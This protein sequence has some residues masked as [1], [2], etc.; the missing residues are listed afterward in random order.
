M[1]TL[2][3]AAWRHRG[4]P[5]RDDVLARRLRETC[6]QLGPTF[7]KA[8][9]LLSTRPDFVPRSYC[10]EL[11][12]CLDQIQP[13]PAAELFAELE[14]AWGCSTKK[15]LKKLELE[16]IG[17]GSL[18]QVYRGELRTGEIVAI[19][20][21]RPGVEAVVAAD[22]RVLRLLAKVFGNRIGTAERGYWLELVAEVER[23]L[24]MEMNYERELQNAEMMRRELIDE[25]AIRIPKMYANLSSRR[26]LVMEYLAGESLLSIMRRSR[27]SKSAAGGARARR[28]IETAMDVLGI[29]G[30]QRSYFHAD[31]HPGNLLLQK[32]GSLALLD[33]GLVQHFSPRLRRGMLMFL[34]GAVLGSPELLIRSARAVARFSPDFDTDT[35]IEVLGVLCERYR[36]ARVSEMSFGQFTFEI[37]ALCLETG[38]QF[39]W[40][41][42]LY[43]R[44]ALHLDGIALTLHPEIV[45][46]EYAERRLLGIYSA[47]LAE[48]IT[49]PGLAIEAIDD[50]WAA[51]KKTPGLIRRLAETLGTAS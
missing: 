21:L 39:P 24:A 12:Q 23:W 46:S 36:G 34:M 51:A 25:P 32:D 9:Q 7:I 27:G 47:A 5:D 10:R 44:S 37:I 43:T 33:F 2:G 48:E 41:I 11:E 35:A 15:K 17:A 50:L 19:K 20:I 29:Q 45:F 6:E 42:L 38:V 28:A 31:L 1:L 40:Q 14:Q 26:V 3:W 49:S 16:P 22:I 8:A 30:L 4:A 18:A 13:L